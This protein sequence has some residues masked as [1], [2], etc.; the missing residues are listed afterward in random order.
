M[1]LLFNVSLHIIYKIVRVFTEYYI[2]ML[3][4]LS[5]GV[6][7]GT[8][9]GISIVTGGGQGFASINVI[10]PLKLSIIKSVR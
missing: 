4:R 3:K 1:V 8:G 5:E 9:G 2:K 7:N 10:T 6:G